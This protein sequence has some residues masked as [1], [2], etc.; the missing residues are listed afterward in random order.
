MLKTTRF[1]QVLVEFRQDGIQ[2]DGP[3]IRSLNKVYEA[4]NYRAG[5]LGGVKWARNREEALG[6][7]VLAVKVSDYFIGKVELDGYIQTGAGLFGFE[8]KNDYP[9]SLE[10]EAKLKVD[11]FGKW[12]KKRRKSLTKR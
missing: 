7:K 5:V 10:Q 11:F 9:N 3:Y 6:W 2:G 4:K 12:A 1:Y 8:W